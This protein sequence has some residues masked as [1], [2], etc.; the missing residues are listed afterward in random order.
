MR[1]SAAA[2]GGRA[3]LAVTAAAVSHSPS[4]VPSPSASLSPSASASASAHHSQCVQVRRRVRALPQPRISHR[5]TLLRLLATRM[6]RHVAVYRSIV[7][8]SAACASFVSRSTSLSRSTF[9]GLLR[10]P[11]SAAAVRKGLGGEQHVRQ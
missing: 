4:A 1:R 9:H 6:R 2:R 7:R 10:S 3:S 8:R 11:V 5:L